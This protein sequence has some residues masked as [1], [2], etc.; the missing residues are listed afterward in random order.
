[1]KNMII[2]RSLPRKQYEPLTQFRGLKL[3]TISQQKRMF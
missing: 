1:M 2:P 3:T